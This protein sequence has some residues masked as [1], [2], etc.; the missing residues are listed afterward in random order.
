MNDV[1]IGSEFY[2][3]GNGILVLGEST[4]GEDELLTV[5]IPR[6]IAGERDQTFSRMFNAYSSWRTETATRMQRDAFWASL[7]FCNFVQKSIG[8]TCDDWPDNTRFTAAALVLP[9]VI[10]QV[11]PTGVLVLGTDQGKFSRPIIEAAKLPCV[12]SPYP[13]RPGGNE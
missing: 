7:A 3:A 13:T 1:W 4:Y 8:S 10:E 12:V 2:S 5:S 6:W 9:S 11:R